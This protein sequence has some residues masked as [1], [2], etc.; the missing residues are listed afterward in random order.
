MLGPGCGFRVVGFAGT[1]VERGSGGIVVLIQGLLPFWKS[2]CSCHVVGVNQ[3]S[4]IQYKN[5]Y[6]TKQDEYK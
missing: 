4:P 5:E 6:V 1:A 2:N 3:Y